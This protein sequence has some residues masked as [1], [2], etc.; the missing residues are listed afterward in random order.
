[1][2]LGTI[3]DT[4]RFFD[5]RWTLEI[6]SSLSERPKRFNA[7]QRDVGNI[8]AKTHRDA[9]QRL[10]DR[11]LVCHPRHG[12]GVNYALYPLGERVLPALRVFVNELSEWDKTRDD[13]RNHRP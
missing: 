11:G 10:V 9:L 12:D 6:L 13:D 4:L 5:H 8:N 1:M 7:L 2:D 3:Y